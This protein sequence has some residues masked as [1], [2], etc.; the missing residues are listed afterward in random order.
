MKVNQQWQP[1]PPVFKVG[2]PVTRTVTIIADGV[3]GNQIPELSF[4]FPDTLKGYADQPQIE[5]QQTPK[6]LKG[7]RKEKWALIPSQPGEITLP[8][9]SVSWWDVTKNQFRTAI[10]PSK[11]IQVHP[12][13]KSSKENISQKAAD[14]QKN[15]STAVVAQNTADANN[16]ANLWKVLTIGFAMLWAGTI[17]IWIVSKN[18]KT[19]KEVSIENNF[20]QKQQVE[21][22]SAAKNVEQALCRGEPVAV[23][24][25]LLKWGNSVWTDDPPDGLEEIG[26]RIPELKNGIKTLNSALYGNHQNGKSL[27]VLKDEFI[28][29]SSTAIKINKSEKESNLPP[30]YPE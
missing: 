25:A 14:T 16:S 28:A 5:T 21:I 3:S 12:V 23:Q 20:K 30:L 19:N 22:K 6:G 8:K 26:D 11:V 29:I 13:S 4:Q 15:K 18:R 17:M 24:S 7:I 27:N 9:I 1:D 10:I 2:E